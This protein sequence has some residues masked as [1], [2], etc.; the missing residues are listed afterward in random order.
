MK[1]LW[2][3]TDVVYTALKNLG[4]KVGPEKTPVI[5]VQMPSLEEGI[6]V[7]NTLYENGVYVNMALPPAIPMGKCL[8]RCSVSAAHTPE[9]LEIVVKAFTAARHKDEAAA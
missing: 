5:G 4:F 8:L 2:A 3:N 6:R 1:K 9:Q 7:W